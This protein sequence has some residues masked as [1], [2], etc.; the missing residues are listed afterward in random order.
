MIASIFVFSRAFGWLE[1]G[2]WATAALI[3]TFAFLLFSWSA[4]ETSTVVADSHGFHPFQFVIFTISGF[5][6][7]HFAGS[8]NS[9]AINQVKN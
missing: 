7:C 4:G 8:K 1:G 9:H 6:F 2:R 5:V 3:G